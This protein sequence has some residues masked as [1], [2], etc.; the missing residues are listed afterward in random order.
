M[1]VFEKVLF[2]ALMDVMDQVWNEQID[3]EDDTS[4]VKFGE[5]EEI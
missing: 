3:G 2:N 5:K 4:S 1:E